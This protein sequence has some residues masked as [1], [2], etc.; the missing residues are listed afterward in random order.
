[1]EL[2]RE[3][4]ELDIS[5]D[6]WNLACGLAMPGIC[7]RMSLTIVMGHKPVLVCLETHIE[8]VRGL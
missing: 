4:Q 1:M 2:E 6:V 8:P 7:I 5:A 3:L